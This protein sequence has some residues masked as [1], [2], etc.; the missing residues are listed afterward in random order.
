MPTLTEPAVERY[1]FFIEGM[2]CASCVTRIEE[3]LRHLIGVVGVHVNPGTATAV[4]RYVPDQVRPM[5]FRRA[6]EQAGPYRAVQ[7][8]PRRGT[9]VAETDYWARHSAPLKRRVV[10]TV[11]LTT[12]VVV[13]TWSGLL[14]RLPPPWSAVLQW[15]VLGCASVIQWWG[16]WSFHTSAVASLRRGAMDMNTLIALGSCAAYG[17]SVVSTVTPDW[18]LRAG[19]EPQFHYDTSSLII[20]FILVGRWF[21]TRAKRTAGDALKALLRLQPPLARVLRGGRERRV[22]LDEVHVGDTFILRPGDRVPVDGLIEEGHSFVN[23]AA[24]TGESLPVEKTVGSPL[25]SGTHNLRG[26]LVAR[27]TRVGRNT[28]LAQVFQLVEEAQSA[29]VPIQRVADRIAG[30][31]VPIVIG[32]AVLTGAAWWLWGP[33]PQSVWAIARMIAV[34]IVACPCALGLATPLALMIGVGRGAHEGMLLRNPAALELASRLTDVVLDKTGTVTWGR[35]QVTSLKSREEADV[36]NWLALAASAERAS[37]HPLG[38][39]IVRAAAAR[40]IALQP[41]NHF[42]AVPGAGLKAVVQG[43]QVLIGNPQLITQAQADW[44]GLRDEVDVIT[45]QGAT[46]VVVAVDGQVR[47]VVGV[48]DTVRPDAAATIKVLAR[49]RVTIHLVTGDQRPTALA[50]AQTLGVTQIHAE[51]LPHQKAAYIQALRQQGKVV[52]MVG[53]G[54]NDAPALVHADLSIAMGR[55]TDLAAETGDIVLLRNEL[56][57]VL[58]AIELSRRMM[59]IIQQN[60]AWAFSYNVLMIPWAAGVF[61]PW[62]GVT[63]PPVIAAAAMAGSSLAVVGNSLRLRQAPRGSRR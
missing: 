46:P 3:T 51:C 16:G 10:V 15:M 61:Y 47:G 25:I 59:R 42:E 2:H 45:Q 7:L 49:R 5:A 24:M 17:A 8:E 33:A 54:I 19:L 14:Q 29:K 9:M 38:E 28:T 32:I 26:R 34:L 30:L 22:P 37:E 40:Q 62:W 50:I 43:H 11:I 58:Q 48:A 35:P 31:F 39:A 63:L 18:L 21:E 56:R 27:A 1:E 44:G 6:I 4:I 41:V 36:T 20:T 52:A 57:G 53:D 12:V 55:A 13:L 23:E 60:L